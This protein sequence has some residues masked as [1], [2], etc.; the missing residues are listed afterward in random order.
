[1]A[2]ELLYLHPQF[3]SNFWKQWQDSVTTLASIQETWLINDHGLNQSFKHVFIHHHCHQQPQSLWWPEQIQWTLN[4]KILHFLQRNLHDSNFEGNTTMSVVITLLELSFIRIEKSP[5]SWWRR[6]SKVNSSSRSHRKN[7]TREDR[8]Q[9]K[10]KKHTPVRTK[11]PV[12][13]LFRD[14]QR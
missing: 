14:H 9:T 6:N 5:F 12:S 13:H 8:K 4:P 11:V 2:K 10:N 3:L 7:Q 1:M